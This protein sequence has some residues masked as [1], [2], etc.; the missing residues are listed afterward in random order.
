M[1]GAPFVASLLLVSKARSPERS[2]LAVGASWSFMELPKSHR[3]QVAPYFGWPFTEV[4][5]Y[6]TQ[7]MVVASLSGHPSNGWSWTLREWIEPAPGKHAHDDM[8]HTVRELGR[9][10]R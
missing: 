3:V 9:G 10:P 8:T 5:S 2:V 1:P 7:R 4:S 6:E